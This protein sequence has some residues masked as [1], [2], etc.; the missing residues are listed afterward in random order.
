[1]RCLT[2][3]TYCYPLCFWLSICLP[4]KHYR[5]SGKIKIQLCVRWSGK[6]NLLFIKCSWEWMGNSCRW[7]N[8]ICVG[9]RDDSYPPAV[10]NNQSNFAKS[11][12][13]AANN[14]QFHFGNSLSWSVTVVSQSRTLTHWVNP[15]LF[16]LSIWA[17][18]YLWR[19]TWRQNIAHYQLNVRLSGHPLVNWTLC[20]TK[21]PWIKLQ[22]SLKM[23]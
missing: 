9:I 4:S 10:L 21:L 14:M 22:Y 2:C 1:M 23:L 15:V 3:K 7:R 5:H 8:G 18:M 6:I 11:S 20:M 13:V 16:Y 17:S 19:L 12:F